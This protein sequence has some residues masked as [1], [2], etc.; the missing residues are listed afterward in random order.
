MLTSQQIL[1]EFVR[2]TAEERLSRYIHD[3]DVANFLRLFLSWTSLVTVRSKL[4]VFDDPD[5]DI[6]RT[7]KDGRADVIV[8]GD[9]HLLGL[10]EFRGIRVMSVAQMLEELGNRKSE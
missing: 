2:I 7:A 10:K 4:K 3:D 9:A 8:S 5:D 6:L 1:D